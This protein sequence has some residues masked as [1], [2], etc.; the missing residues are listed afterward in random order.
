MI[1]LYLEKNSA[2]NPKLSL[3]AMNAYLK[4]CRSQDNRIR[5]LAL[6]TLSN[7]LTTT[8]IEFT[9]QMVPE[10]LKDK[11]AYVRRNAVIAALK[12]YYR[13][14]EFFEEQKFVD[15]FYDLLKDP[16]SS[17]ALAAISALNEIMVSEGG[18]AVNQKIAI[19]LL[20]RFNDF[21]WYGKSVVV[22]CI[23]RYA[24]SNDNEMFNIMNLLD[25]SL[26]R[27]H[28]PLLL[29]I[30]NCFFKFTKGK[31][32]VFRSMVK[33]AAKVLL[34]LISSSEN[35]ALYDMLKHFKIFL[36]D[37]VFSA[38]VRPEWERFLCQP[39]E[40]DY[41]IKLKMDILVR[42]ADS[43]SKDRILSEFEEYICEKRNVVAV[44]ALDCLAG[45][46]RKFP[47]KAL[48]VLK[49]MLILIKGVGLRPGMLRLVT[50]AARLTHKKLPTAF[51]TH[52]E[53]LLVD[54]RVRNDEPLDVM[55]CLLAL[56]PHL[57]KAPYLLEDLVDDLLKGKWDDFNIAETLL[58]VSV[59]MFLLRPGETVSI[60]SKLLG[61]F[62]DEELFGEYLEELEK[63]VPAR[64]RVLVLFTNTDLQSRAQFYYSALRHSPEELKRVVR[65]DARE[66]VQGGKK[67]ARQGSLY[68]EYERFG[69]NNLGVIYR[70][71]EEMFIR[72]L[73]FFLPT[74]E[75]KREA[76][77]EE[78]EEG[79]EEEEEES[80]GEVGSS[81][82][83]SVTESDSAES[84]EEGS[85]SEYGS[86]DEETGSDEKEE[87]DS[88]NVSGS[89]SLDLLNSGPSV[90]N[91]KS[92]DLDFLGLDPA[93]KIVK[94]SECESSVGIKQFTENFEIE[95]DDFQEKWMNLKH[96]YEDEAMISSSDLDSWEDDDFIEK[97]FGK[98]RVYTLAAGSQLSLDQSNKSKYLR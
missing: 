13:R 6:R 83:E 57:D 56:G 30:L 8:A 15:T 25:D 22:E 85:E 58:R 55:K 12:L 28:R 19:Y 75:V 62:L 63:D 18:M 17:V 37:S 89:D 95:E 10:M 4:D 45:L 86:E 73:E 2:V 36:S 65:R 64:E 76:E 67:G 78:E 27:N 5:G 52:L 32:K 93:P 43:D 34:S 47:K 66:V 94:E 9:Q 68:S 82:D 81:D 92:G 60:L 41:V 84:E 46:L 11:S 29:A 26:K 80:E 21:N 42:L 98:W 35:E 70:Q 96:E 3:M 49:K 44:Y 72:P 38:L 77:D 33:R 71:D 54:E 61:F 91:Q 1:Y 79:E 50:T 40:P 87:G 74:R 24:P 14:R 39:F 48:D 16:H 7:V 97:V 20:N 23:G 59:E 53:T 31:T 88:E 51:L 90:P 69:L